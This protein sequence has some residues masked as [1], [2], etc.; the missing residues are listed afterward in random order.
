MSHHSHG[1]VLAEHERGPIEL[2]DMVEPG[3]DAVKQASQVESARHRG[4]NVSQVVGQA[5]LL[6]F[7]L[8]FH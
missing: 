4:G 7:R 1:V 3:E 6:L 5:T 2:Q 8:E